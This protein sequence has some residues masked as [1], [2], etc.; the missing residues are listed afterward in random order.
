MGLRIRVAAVCKRDDTLLL[1]EHEKQRQ[2]YFLLPGGGMKRGEPAEDAVV[3]EVLEETGIKV[4][5]KRLVCI[6]ESISPGRERHIVHF[7]YDTVVVAGEPGQSHDSRVRQ[8]LFVPM[9]SI[10]ELTLH[11]PVQAWLWERAETGFLSEP[12]YLGSMWV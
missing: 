11:P 8:S 9:Q 7:I 6:C 5:P 4:E 10:S 1:V 2:R 12:E 3:R